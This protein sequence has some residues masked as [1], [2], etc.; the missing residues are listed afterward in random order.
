L[1]KYRNDSLQISKWQVITL[2]DKI[3]I[4]H[5]T[6]WRIPLWNIWICISITIYSS[7][8]YH[9]SNSLFVIFFIYSGCSWVK[10]RFHSLLIH[11]ILLSNYSGLSVSIDIVFPGGRGLANT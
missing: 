10:H 2:S 3:L 9:L 11:Q 4:H 5:E 1:K 8:H 7:L 6:N